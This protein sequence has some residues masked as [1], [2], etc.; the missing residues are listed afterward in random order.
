MRFVAWVCCI[1]ADLRIVWICLHGLVLFGMLSLFY[2]ASTVWFS[3]LVFALLN[4]V[5]LLVLWVCAYYL[6]AILWILLVVF[7]CCYVYRLLVDWF[8]FWSLWVA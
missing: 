3:C 2:I 5:C 7:L 1:A 8:V 6:V 4:F